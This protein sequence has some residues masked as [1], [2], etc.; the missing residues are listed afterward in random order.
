VRPGD[1]L[2]TIASHLLPP[3]AEDTRVIETWHA[4]HRANHSRIGDDPDLIL[5]GT[6]LVVPDL[7]AP[8]REEQP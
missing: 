2:W 8:D 3:G 1:S 5:P 4:L 6:R 7:T